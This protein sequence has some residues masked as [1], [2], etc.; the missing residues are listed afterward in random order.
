VSIAATAW[1]TDHVKVADAASELLRD[2]LGEATLS[3]RLVVGV[4]SLP[5][6]SPVE[7]EVILE[8]TP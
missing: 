5:L 4:A 6:G 3:C 2:V 7:L 8:V 1:F